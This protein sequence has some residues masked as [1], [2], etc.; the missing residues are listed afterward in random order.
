VNGPGQ[1]D[2]ACK[3]VFAMR[4]QSLWASINND[5][6][7]QGSL[8]HKGTVIAGELLCLRSKPTAVTANKGIDI[9][10]KLLIFWFC[11][12]A[13][14]GHGQ[15]GHRHCRQATNFFTASQM[16]VAPQGL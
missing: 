4:A 15:R 7:M 2:L 1:D 11:Q 13:N 5:N 14:S 6:G 16:A 12:Q 10:G 8:C 9:A 3:V